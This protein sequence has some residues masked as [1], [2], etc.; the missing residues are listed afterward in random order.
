MKYTLFKATPQNFPITDIGTS[1]QFNQAVHGTAEK[2][3]RGFQLK[4]NGISSRQGDFILVLSYDEQDIITSTSQYDIVAKVKIEYMTTEADDTLLSYINAEDL[5]SDD[6]FMWGYAIGNKEFMKD[7]INE[8]SLV[9]WVKY[10][11]PQDRDRA[12]A[13]ITSENVL[14][15][16]GVEIGDRDAIRPSIVSSNCAFAWALNIPEERPAM[17][18][19]ITDP[20]WIEAWNIEF[21]EDKIV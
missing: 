3:D 14:C 10:V 6:A 2:Q 16:W 11:Y 19:R 13:S 8:Q 20:I 15:D 9:N 17:K 12:L 7:F 4:P 21:P 5:S 1:V 18:S